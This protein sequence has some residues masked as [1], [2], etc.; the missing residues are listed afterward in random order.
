[1]NALDDFDTD[2]LLESAVS[3]DDRAAEV[4]LRRYRQRIRTL[5]GVRL[6]SQMAGRI[7]ASDVVQDVM[8]TAHRRL[9]EYL[10]DRPITFYAWLRQIA[11]NRL[12]DLYRQHCLAEKRSVH[13]EEALLSHVNDESA[14][15]LA[16]R[17]LQSACWVPAAFSRPIRGNRAAYP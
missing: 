15:M 14:A 11:L 1:M 6:D 9:D 12:T 7:D 17:F 16:E 4:L 13:R 2:Q 3:G 5:V 8:V 10:R